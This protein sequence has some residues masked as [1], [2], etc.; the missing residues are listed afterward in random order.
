M[1]LAV[2][3]ETAVATAAL[4]SIVTVVALGI[5][6]G[7]CSQ[8]AKLCYDALVQRDVPDVVRPVNLH[9]APFRRRCTLCRGCSVHPKGAG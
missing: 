5:V 2:D 8:L 6:A 3:A 9:A 4:Y 7:H 1:V